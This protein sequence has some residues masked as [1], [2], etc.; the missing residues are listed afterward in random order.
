MKQETRDFPGTNGEKMT[1][2]ELGKRLGRYQKAEFRWLCAGL[3]AIAGGIISY[4]AVKEPALKAILTGVLFFGGLCCAIFL[5][6]GARRK[7]NALLGEQ[8]GDF[9]R[10]ELEK[11]FGPEPVVPRMPIGEELIRSIHLLD[12]RWEECGTADFREGVHRGVTFSAANV[13]LDH[14]YRRG[15]PHEGY[16]T[17]SDTVFKGIVLRCGT[18]ETAAAPV[19]VVRRG[20]CGTGEREFDRLFRVMAREERDAARLLTPRFTA[21]LE[22]F[23]QRTGG[24]LLALSWEGSVLTLALETDRPFA[25]VGRY[26][27]MGDPE[28]VR[29]SYVASLTGM[30]QMLDLLTENTEIIGG[31]GHEEHS[32]KEDVEK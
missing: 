9:F 26:V 5:S 19:C 24:R 4:F 11:A 7:L 22:S 25:A 20:E 2:A 21:L 31:S 13:R 32:Y 8:M 30:G 18:C 12:G 23:G 14:V 1:D 6:G 28:A 10:A 16:E 3:I 15:A 17:C 27:D 29:K